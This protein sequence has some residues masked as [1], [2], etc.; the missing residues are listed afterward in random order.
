MTTRNACGTHMGLKLHIDLNEPL[1]P[2]CD[3]LANECA[4]IGVG[5]RLSAERRHPLPDNTQPVR[6]LRAIIAILAAAMSPK[7][8]P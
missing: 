1:C 7:T 2:T 4:L 5:I 6:D 3:D 8:K